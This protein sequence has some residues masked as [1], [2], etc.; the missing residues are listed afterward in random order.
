M[1]KNTKNKVLSL[2]LM[3]FGLGSVFIKFTIIDLFYLL[4]IIYYM[5]K[6]ISIRKNKNY[7]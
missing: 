7:T 6:Y 3:V 2:C 1:T 5:I 4:F